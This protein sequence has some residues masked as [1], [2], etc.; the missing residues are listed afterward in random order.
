VSYT[1]AGIVSYRGAYSIQNQESRGSCR[2][3]RDGPIGRS[4]GSGE[5]HV[6]SR[7]CLLEEKILFSWVADRI[8]GAGVM[9]E[10]RSS[11]MGRSRSRGSGVVT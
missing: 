5:G 6:E 4:R 7:E 11:P 2:E 10:S 9:W 8:R 1:G 3:S